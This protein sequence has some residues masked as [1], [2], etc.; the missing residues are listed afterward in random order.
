MD[1]TFQKSP[2][3]QRL[4]GMK[5]RAWL[6]RLTY[7]LEQRLVVQG[8]SHKEM[9]DRV[10]RWDYAQVD[11][12]A[13][14]KAE[15]DPDELRAALQLVRDEPEQGFA[16]L[17]DLALGGSVIAMTAVGECY[18]WGRG[19]TESAAKAETWL[20]KA[21]EA[22]SQRALLT[23]GKALWSRGELD[24]AE[25]VFRRG[26]EADWPPAL[27][28]LAVVLLHKKDDR[29]TRRQARTLL[30]RA[31]ARGSLAAQWKLASDTTRGRFGLFEIPGGLRQMARL[32]PEW[33]AWHDGQRKAAKRRTPTGETVH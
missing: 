25:A 23:Y 10:M 14:W 12:S 13:L 30:E 29:A 18:Y 15:S 9:R 26:V 1:E 32:A 17:L 3:R 24:R 6:L 28:W 22:G 16:D 8:P 27:Y 2:A 31:A 4:R 20:S 19:V 11:H 33:M 21:F 5:L 7:W